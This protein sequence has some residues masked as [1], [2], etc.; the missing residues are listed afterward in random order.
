[1]SFK[2]SG[3]Q[4]DLVSTTRQAKLNAWLAFRGIQ[5]KDLANRLGVHPS[6]ISRIIRGERRPAK[7]IAELVALGIP[8]HL[9]PQPGP[10]PGRPSKHAVR[11][12]IPTIRNGE[13]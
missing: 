2:Q 1:M 3:Q 12:G 5:K 6:M 7:R 8:A 10:S 11:D 13:D 9:L 4:F